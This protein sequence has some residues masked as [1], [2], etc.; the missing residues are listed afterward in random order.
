MSGELVEW[1][2]G[3]RKLLFGT[4][5]GAAL[6]HGLQA[7]AV[8]TI[9]AT[10]QKNKGVFSLT[11]RTFDEP[12]WKV[13]GRYIKPL[14][15]AFPALST[16]NHI[17]SA[18]RF[19]KK[20]AIVTEGEANALRWGEYAASAALMF[21]IIAQLSGTTDAPLLVMIV[22]L[23]VA[24]QLCGYFIENSGDPGLQFTVIGWILF[25]AI[26]IPIVWKFIDAVLEAR[27]DPM[28]DIPGV[29]FAIVAI[30][31]TLFAS[32]GVAS[33][34]F[35]NRRSIRQIVSREITYTSLSFVAKT[36]L[37]WLSVG[38]ALNAGPLNQ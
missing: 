36:L 34:Y 24:L 35:R 10:S 17:V 37:L 18:V 19:G 27:K 23:N 6:F 9:L 30:Q 15:V 13:S 8:G 31:V 32:F 22:L 1:N 16:I 5:I 11:Q 28:A 29:V 21:W 33:L 7:V 12:R 38:G 26:W 4:H 14:L 2:N 25:A 3:K 20:D